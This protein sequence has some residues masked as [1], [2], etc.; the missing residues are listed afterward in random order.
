MQKITFND[1]VKSV[2]MFFTNKEIDEK[3]LELKDKRIEEIKERFSHI[4]T[5][6]GLEQF[7]RTYPDSLNNLLTILGVSSEN[8][9]RVISMFRIERGFSFASEWSLSATRN[10][11]LTDKNMM[12]R[13]CSL[14]LDGDTDES[15]KSKIPEYKLTNFQI[16]KS[17]ID[18]L[19][20][21][22][23]LG[24][25]VRK[26]ID[27]QYN[28]DISAI[29]IRKIEGLLH[30]AHRNKG[31]YLEKNIVVDPV[32][33]GTR[34]IQVNYILGRNQLGLPKYYIKYSFNITT[35]SSQS[36]FKRSVKDLRDYIHNNNPE[37]KQII[38]L[39][40][41]GW[42]GRHADLNASWEYSDYCLNLNNLEKLTEILK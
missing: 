9:K 7:I 1:F 8:F 20:N 40:G 36:D 16:N 15:L 11:I 35:S 39:D 31:L 26:E 27:S 37:A 24:I 19:K 3:Y 32:G 33:N 21:D 17:V 13:V 41:V 5:K 22:D 30:T 6:E 2:T 4:G 34:D 25:L 23:F 12:D 42:I 18:R 29:N 38:I 10:Y 28:S 14:F